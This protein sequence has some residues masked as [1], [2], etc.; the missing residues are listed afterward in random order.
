MSLNEDALTDWLVEY[1][2]ADSELMNHGERGSAGS[3]LGQPRTAR[4]SASTDWT[5]RT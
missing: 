3:D 4:S 5:G 1:L 2:E